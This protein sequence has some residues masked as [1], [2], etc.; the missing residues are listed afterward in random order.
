MGDARLNYQEIMYGFF[1]LTLKGQT[2][3]ADREPAQS[4]LLHDGQQQV[5]LV[6]CLAAEG[7]DAGH[8]LPLERRQ[9]QHAERRR[10]PH[11]HA[12]AGTGTPD[13]FTYDPMDPVPTLGGYRVGSD[14]EG[15]GGSFDQRKIE[16]RK[17]SWSTRA[18]RSTKAPRLPD[19]SRRR[20]TSPRTS[21]TR[22]SPSR[23][24]TSIPDGRAF[25]LDESIQRMRYRD[26]YD[27]PL[28]WMEKDKVYKVTLQPL[29]T[30]NY[31][32]PGHRLRV[33]VSSSSFPRFERNLNTGGRN[34]DE[35]KGVVAHSAVHHSAE[36]PV[37][38]DDHGGEEVAI[39]LARN[40]LSQGAYYTYKRE[41]FSEGRK[42]R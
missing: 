28:V 23:S 1:D 8:L 42:S 38:G 36:H 12:P 15:R 7:R 21:R 3:E 16:E 29:V 14:P 4:A 39:G 26:G 27:K 34:Y 32:L 31:F 2:N 20:S 9:R 10:P 18:S 24:L 37:V 13:R 33:E 25:N 17:T 19:R 35:V 6:G 40:L 22:T 11:T 30:S 5:E 41:E